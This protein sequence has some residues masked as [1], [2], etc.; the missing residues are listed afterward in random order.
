MIVEEVKIQTGESTRTVKELRQ[1]LKD[2]K[3]QLL[4]TQKGTEE[5]GEAMRKAANIQKELKDQMQE[6]NNSA[7]DFGQMMGNSTKIMAGVSGAITAATGALSLFGIENEEAQKKITATMTALIGI[8]QGLSA[9]DN[10]IKAF[11]A[12]TIAIN[13]SSKSLGVFKTALISTGIGALVVILA[14]IIAYWDEFTEAIGLSSEQMERLGDI[15]RGVFNV[16]ASGLKGIAQA[17]GKL[18]KGDFAGAW[19]SLKD[20]FNVVQN[21]NDGVTASVNKREEERTRKARE[22]AA[23][24]AQAAEQEYQ[25][26]IA[27]AKKL[28]QFE[29]DM[30]AAKLRGEE[31]KNKYT[32]EAFDRQMKYF[33]ALEKVYKK[34]SDEYRDLLLEKEQYLQDWENHF[35]SI[36]DEFDAGFE[37]EREKL[38]KRYNILIEAAEKEGRD[39]TAIREWYNSELER[40]DK[41]AR[42]E[43]IKLLE[44]FD[45][46]LLTEQQKLDKRYE[47]LIAAA[48]REGRDT[49]DIINWYNAEKKRIDDEARADDRALLESFQDELMTEQEHLDQRYA[50]LIAAAE[51]EG[52]DTL[53]IQE[54]YEK[55][56]T[57]IVKEEEDKQT[58]IRQAHIKTYTGIASSIGDILNSMSD[59]MEQGTEEQK[60]MA[61][62][63]TTIQMLVGVATAISGAFT[64]K[65]GPWDIVLAAAQAA[66]I[67]ASGIASIVKINQVKADGSGTSTSTP[68]ISI[69]SVVNASQ[70]FSQ[71]VDGALTQTAITDQRVYVLEH[72]ITETQNK[73]QVA[74]SRATY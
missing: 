48:E 60:G 17:L 39:L 30:E 57:R 19:Q 4:N 66:A 14:S 53:A 31:S 6:V 45:E 8:T 44:S 40:L 70:D 32:Q 67:A 27:A 42:A 47:M 61:I 20:G 64:T 25:K 28:A 71:S 41:E 74:E 37:T 3:D 10:G 72:D 49:L 36:L 15:A 11:K 2:L 5:Y 22:E 51:R 59:M 16:L 35:I 7:M 43:D 38:D 9:M 18:L 1:E 34:D 24:R 13:A 68:A 12:L 46:D 63:A 29:R 23:K 73:V 26:R 21:F 56:K 58:A 50:M 65:S 54:W 55:E 69:P 52:Q 33:E 62:A